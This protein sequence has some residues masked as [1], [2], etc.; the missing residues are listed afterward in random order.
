[1]ILVGSPHRPGDPDCERIQRAMSTQTGTGLTSVTVSNFRTI[2]HTVSVSLGRITA[3]VGPNGSGKSS[4]ADTFRFVSDALRMGLEAAITKRHGIAA[5][6]RWSPGH[7]FD[8]SV[9]I[10]FEIAHRTGYYE[11]TLTGDRSEEYRVKREAMW[12]TNPDLL[13]GGDFIFEVADGQ[14]RSSAAD[15]RP[16]VDPLSLALPLLAGDRR[17]KPVADALRY[18]EI[19]SIF[20]D[21]LREPQKFDPAKP[22]HEHGNNWCSILKGMDEEKWEPELVAALGALTG[23]I[24]SI[25]VEPVGGFLTARFRHPYDEPRPGIRKRDKWFDASQESDGTLRVAGILTALLQ[26]PPL[27]LVGIEEPELTVHPGAIPLLFDH[28][29]QASL[30]SQVLLTTHSPELLDLL[31]ADDV[32]IVSRSEGATNVSGMQLS[33]REAVKTRLLTVSELVRTGALKAEPR[34]ADPEIQGRLDL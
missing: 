14:W 20:P 16:Q 24:D 15:L 6:R 5:V 7:P 12:F 1:L 3:L 4:V 22:M 32:R 34:V 18:V 27:T 21:T 29:K 28:I 2:G 9:R 10:D 31:D 26:E 33:Q 17:V 19:Y 13:G 25:R 23:D 11:F 30:R 8:L